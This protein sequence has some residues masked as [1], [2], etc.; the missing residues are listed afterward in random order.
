MP[1]QKNSKPIS[2][3][4]KTRIIRLLLITIGGFSFLYLAIYLA[5]WARVNPGNTLSEIMVFGV[6]ALI[7]LLIIFNNLKLLKMVVDAFRNHD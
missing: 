4:I 3:N 7:V 5:A 1:S 6:I 2:N